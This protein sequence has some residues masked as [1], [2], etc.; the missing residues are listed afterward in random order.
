MAALIKKYG[1]FYLVHAVT[2]SFLCAYSL[3]ANAPNFPFLPALFLPIYLSG[4]VAIS[5]RETGDPLMGI[6]PVTT[7][8]IMNVKLILALVFVVVGWV[9]MGFFTLLQG[10]DSQLMQ[11]VMKLNTLGAIHAL[12]L[13]VAY[14]LGIHFFGWPSFHK[15]IILM[16]VVAAVF[17][18][19]F[20]IGLAE[21]GH[22][23]PGMFPLIPFL[24]SMPIMML[25]ALSV[26]ALAVFSWVLR[27]GP[28]N[29]TKP[30]EQ[31]C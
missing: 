24:D 14:Q 4:A 27:R 16:A 5:E 19:A 23:H 8:E 1:M 12:M 11:Q 17:G 9:N 28:W 10:L 29:P 18:V 31:I 30:N 20:F 6:L 13:A 26:G 22:N 7:G 15:V 3:A 2:F 25:V 21:S